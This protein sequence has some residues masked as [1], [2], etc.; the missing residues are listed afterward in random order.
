MVGDNHTTSNSK[1]PRVVLPI[2]EMLIVCAVLSLLYAFVMPAVNI[3]RER[4]HLPPVH[5]FLMPFYETQQQLWCFIAAFPVITTS[6]LGTLVILMRLFL[7]PS[8]RA[9]FPWRQRH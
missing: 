3:A 9:R 6:C 4:Q 1:C 8:V 7:P 2:S 5:A